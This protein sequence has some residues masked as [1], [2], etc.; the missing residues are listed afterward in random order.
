MRKRAAKIV[1][2]PPLGPPDQD[3]PLCLQW[4]DPVP[5]ASPVTLRRRAPSGPRRKSGD[6]YPVDIQVLGVVLEVS[7]PGSR[8]VADPQPGGRRRNVPGRC[9]QEPPIQVELNPGRTIGSVV[10]E[11]PLGASGHERGAPGILEAGGRGPSA[12]IYG[13]SGNPRPPPSAGLRPVGPFE[14]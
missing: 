4:S 12:L 14:S 8:P 6:P 2:K 7:G 1:S 9:V 13:A 11:R 5:K 3:D 10:P